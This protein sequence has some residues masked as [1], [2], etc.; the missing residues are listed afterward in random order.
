MRT[1]TEGE[2]L[3]GA[4]G[5]AFLVE[6]VSLEDDFLLIDI[7]RA[8]DADDTGAMSQQFDRDEFEAFC[9]HEGIVSQ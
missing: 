6:A 5:S 4:D 1:P 3:I 9:Q 2:R 8:E 7:I